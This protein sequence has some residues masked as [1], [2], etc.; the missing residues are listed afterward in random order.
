MWQEVLE[1]FLRIRKQKAC[2]KHFAQLEAL[3]DARASLPESGNA[4]PSAGADLGKHLEEC[5]GC[6]EALES[7]EL[8]GRLLREARGP[9]ARPGDF[10]AARVSAQVRPKA[11]QRRAPAD[12]LQ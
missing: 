11:E 9:E 12:F 10:F 2:R 6:R 5:A 7:A 3:L 1:M 4:A 8:A